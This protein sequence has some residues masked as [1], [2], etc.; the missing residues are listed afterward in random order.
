M[1]SSFPRSTGSTLKANRRCPRHHEINILLLGPTGVGKSTFINA[2]INYITYNTLEEAINGEMQ[3]VIPSQF[4]HTEFQ[5]FT[6]QT[7][8]V[9]SEDKYEKFSTHGESGTQQCRSFVFPIGTRNLRFIDT[10]GIGDTR[11]IEQ[12]AKN[13]QEILNHISEYKHLNAVFIMLKP[14]EERLTVSF[15][16]VVNEL[17]RHLHIELAANLM[18]V[19]TNA[20]S[21]F[22]KPG[23]STPALRALL[24]KHGLEYKVNIPFSTAN[25]FLFDNEAFRY[26]ALCKNNIQVDNEQRESYTKSWDHSVAE[27]SRLM[28]TVNACKPHRVRNTISL[29][30]AEQLIR[31]LPR[32]IAETAK[33]IEDNV[34]LAKDQQGKIRSDVQSSSEGILQN[35]VRIIR[36]EH[37]RTVCVSEKCCRVIDENGKKRIQ[38]LSICHEQCYL[39][40]V[41]QE[42]LYDPKLQDCFCM[43][44]DCHWLQHKH[45]TYECITNPVRMRSST[46]NL[47]NIEQRINDL[48]EEQRKIQDVYK[49]LV[50]F[51][52]TNALLP[53][54]DDFLDYLEYFIRE[55]Q[56]IRNSG[57]NNA[58]IIVNLQRLKD[59]YKQ[60]MDLFKRTVEEQKGTTN[61]IE[62]LKAS[63]ILDLVNELYQLP[64]T[65]QQIRQQVEGIVIG[66]E[67]GN[68]QREIYVDLPTTA[69]SS[70]VMRQLEE[71]IFPDE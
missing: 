63:Q 33:L 2:F 31:K 7:I 29:N 66:Q 22:F 44:C 11:G 23:S 36:L 52:Y 39:N 32:P 21:T 55:E 26:L 58:Q 20:H 9:G 69:A 19:F 10:P 56:T 13:F 17:L 37:P 47:S 61:T 59:E 15:R 42:T 24:N 34:R 54:N 51:L 25:S 40:G 43:V 50:R 4:F 18:F 35:E 48:R 1:T 45:I 65:G 30:E 27:Y 6:E 67:K 64:I 38:Y 12:D 8:K 5:T 68:A 60:E 53:A 57:G 16:F 41:Q 3:Y 46:G 14:N 62:T 71:I 49:K 70:K 28:K